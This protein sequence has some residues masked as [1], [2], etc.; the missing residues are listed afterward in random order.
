MK[1]AGPLTTSKKNTDTYGWS[2][3]RKGDNAINTNERPS[4]LRE[5]EQPYYMRV[6]FNASSKSYHDQHLDGGH[7]ASISPNRN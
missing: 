7:T 1:P 3:A 4:E 5:E 6:P 2:S